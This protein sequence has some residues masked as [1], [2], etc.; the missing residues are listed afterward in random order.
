M[1]INK[2]IMFNFG[3]MMGVII[4][5]SSN[6]WF[7]VWMG[8]ELSLMC[9]IPIMS[10]K[11][12]LNS[13]SCIKYF[14]IQSLS[15]S[16]MMMG[17]IMMSMKSD[18]KLM[19]MLAIMLK[20]GMPPF[21]TWALSIIEGMNYYSILIFITLM[22]M[23]PFQMLSYMNTNLALFTTLGL[24]VGSISGLNQNSIKKL[25]LYSSIFNMSLI[26]SC[27]SSYMIWMNYFWLYFISMIMFNSIIMKMGINFINQMMF[28]NY[29]NLTKIMCWVSLLSMGGFPPTLTFYSKFLVLKH[30]NSINNHIIMVMI[31]ISSLIVMF[32]YM[33]M[34]FLSIMFFHDL[35]KWLIM[36]K[37]K[38]YS[39][40][41]M[42]LILFTTAFFNLK[43]F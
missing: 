6:N 7:S 36:I 32:F 16:I 37:A 18:D 3:M 15:S 31:I 29:S 26:I 25:I 14:I 41:V 5:M 42:S 8:L 20:L 43:S 11:N 24:M 30:L 9:F 12:K 23:I 38:F 27:I 17:V 1:L 19:L 40:M 28:N 35:P 10:A 13:E 33:R 4:S 34:I 21:H 39:S 22:K 2:K